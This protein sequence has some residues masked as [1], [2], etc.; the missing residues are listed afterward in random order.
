MKLQLTDRG[1]SEKRDVAPSLLA[2]HF[3]LLT[4]FA[5]RVICSLQVGADGQSHLLWSHDLRAQL[6]RSLSAAAVKLTCLAGVPGGS[7]KGQPVAVLA[8]STSS[9][10]DP[11]QV[12]GSLCILLLGKKHH[13]T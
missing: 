11:E 12:L 5:S 7:L 2:C 6:K 3:S 9:G 1:W 13:N 8:A 4:Y 10:S